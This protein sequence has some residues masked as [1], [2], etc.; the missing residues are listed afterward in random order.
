MTN[1]LRA[2]SR[3]TFMSVC[4]KVA[5]SFALA[6]GIAP[7]QTL[8]AEES[9]VAAQSRSGPWDLSWTKRLSGTTDRA[10]FDWPGLGDPADPTMLYLAERYLDNCRDAYGDSRHEVRTVL[11]IRTQA[12]PAALSDATWARFHVGAEYNVKD[13]NT[14]QIAEVNPFLHRSPNAV[15][16]VVV[17]TIPDLMQRGSIVL[18]CDFAL[19]NLAKRLAGKTGASADEVHTQ[20]RAGLI[21]GAFAVPSGIFGL[22]RAQNAG[23][24]LVRQ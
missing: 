20:L 19:R 11:N 6:T 9:D 17:P 18:V 23:C 2:A 10:V 13:P 14:A 3:R 8:S 22:A 5:A 12:V 4:G 16:D 1:R 21:D 7:V 15:P 24:A